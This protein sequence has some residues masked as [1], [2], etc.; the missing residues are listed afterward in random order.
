MEFLNHDIALE[1]PQLKDK[2]QSMKMLHP[3]F[4]RLCQSYDEV[5]HA[6]TKSEMGGAV[7]TGEDLEAL[8]KQRL[9]LKDEIVRM[10]HSA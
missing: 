5:N 8:K 6:I 1:F 7:M 3:H 9:N 4:A 2:I 10:L